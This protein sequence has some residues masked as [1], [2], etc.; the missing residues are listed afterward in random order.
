MCLGHETLS[1]SLLL[2][3]TRCNSWLCGFTAVL[4][5]AFVLQSLATP[6]GLSIGTSLKTNCRRSSSA[7]G[8]SDSRNRR[9]PKKANW[10]PKVGR[11]SLQ[12][13]DMASPEALCRSQAALRLSGLA[14]LRDG[15]G[16]RRRRWAFEGT[17][18]RGSRR[19]PRQSCSRNLTSAHSFLGLAWPGSGLNSSKQLAGEVSTQTLAFD[20]ESS[21]TVSKSTLRPSLVRQRRCL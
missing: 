1:L 4:S 7:R 12:S 20:S 3:V 9:S 2:R 17:A 11:R 19:P 8:S 18:P 16:Q 5:S 6:S 10:P 15:P 14:F 21:E 13:I